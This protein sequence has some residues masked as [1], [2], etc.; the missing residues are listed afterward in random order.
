MALRILFAVAPGTAALLAALVL[1]RYLLNLDTITT[2]R[3]R[4]E[5]RR[6]AV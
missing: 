5:S 3:F 1:R 6:V 4:L 2:L